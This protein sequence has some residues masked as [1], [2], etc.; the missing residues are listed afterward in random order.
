VSGDVEPQEVFDLA[1]TIYGPL[2]RAAVPERKRNAIPPMNS[3]AQ[4]SLEHEAIREPVAQIVYRAPSYRNNKEES[5]ALQVLQEIMG[6]GSTSRLYKS[7]VV[8]QKIASSAGMAYNADTWDETSL[9]LYAS[10]LPGKTLDEVRDALQAELRK[11]VANGVAAQELSEAKS[12]MNDATMYALD[13]LTGPAMIFGQGLATGSTLDDIEYWPSLISQVTAEQ[14]LATAK[15]H[16]DPDHYGTHPPV[17]GYLVPP[18]PKTEEA[19]I[20][21]QPEKKNP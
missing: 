4:I 11:L 2:P 14:I 5:L 9:W 10:P 3:V 18:A 6:G 19:P 8:D 12:R 16:I 13:S 7:L 1:K 15:K 21:E 17:I 20:A